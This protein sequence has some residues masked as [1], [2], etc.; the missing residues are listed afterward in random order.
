M[1]FGIQLEPI[2]RLVDH[3]E[4]P[5]AFEVT[6]ILDVDTMLARPVEEPWT[7]D[8]DAAH[9]RPTAWS[10]TFDVSKWGLLAAYLDDVRI[11][12]AVVARATPDVYMLRGRDDLAVLWDL[13]VAPEHRGTGVGRALV[14]EV[15]R[16]SRVMGCVDLEVETQQINLG[17]CRFYEAMGFTVASVDPEAYA[18]L[19]GET[20]II[21]HKA[22]G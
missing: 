3:A 22:L 10:D 7:K 12:G 16:Y 14:A 4:I 8:Y 18:E 17:A 1:S 13:R 6:E 2:E 21:W 11:G 15:E 9:T 19:P 20:Q 5:V